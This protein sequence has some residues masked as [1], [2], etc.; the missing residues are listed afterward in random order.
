F[1]VEP[2]INLGTHHTKVL[3]DGWTVV[4]LDGL[5]SVHCEHTIAVTEEGPEVL[6]RVPVKV[7]QEE[8]LQAAGV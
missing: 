4:T 5:P 7:R 6:T 3:S 2:M 1:A 8:Q